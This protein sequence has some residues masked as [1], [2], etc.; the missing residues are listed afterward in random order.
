MTPP[1]QK[2]FSACPCMDWV[3]VL[4]TLWCFLQVLLRAARS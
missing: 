4:S 1:V 2:Q 3:S